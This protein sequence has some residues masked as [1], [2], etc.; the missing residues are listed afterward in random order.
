MA[1]NDL[2]RNG[3]HA[4]ADDHEEVEGSRADDGAW[5]EVVGFEFLADDL[6]HGK[7]DFWKAR[8]S[9]IQKLQLSQLK[10]FG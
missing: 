4:D 1:A 2:T 3:V 6:N 10:Y 8:K 7:Q 5:T 9:G